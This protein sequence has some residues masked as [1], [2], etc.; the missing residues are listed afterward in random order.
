VESLRAGQT[1]WSRLLFWLLIAFVVL[2]VVV[3]LASQTL[4][5]EA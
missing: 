5:S 3:Y 4:T 2:I 1:N